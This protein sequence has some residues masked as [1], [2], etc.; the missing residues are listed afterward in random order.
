MK[1]PEIASLLVKGRDIAKDGYLSE[2]VSV[3]RGR[4]SLFDETIQVVLG[5]AVETPSRF[6]MSKL[7]V[8]FDEDLDPL[9]K[10]DLWDGKNLGQE[11]VL[12]GEKK[13]SLHSSCFFFDRYG[14]D[15]AMADDGLFQIPNLMVALNFE[16]IRTTRGWIRPWEKFD[17]TREAEDT[18][19][20]TASPIMIVRSAESV[21]MPRELGHLLPA[22]EDEGHFAAN[23]FAEFYRELSFRRLAAVLPS[24]LWNRDSKTLA[25]VRGSV[26]REGEFDP[27]ATY[28]ANVYEVIKSACRWIY[29]PSSQAEVRHGLLTSELARLW[30]QSSSWFDGLKDRLQPSLESARTAYQLHVGSL[31]AES[32]RSLAELRKALIEESARVQ[33]MTSELLTSLWRDFLIATGALV[34]HFVALAESKPENRRWV[35]SAAVIFVAISGVLTYTSQLR[36]LHVS[37]LALEAWRKRVYSFVTEADY[38]ALAAEPMGKVNRT[39]WFIA[40]PVALLYLA[41]LVLLLYFGWADI[42]T[43]FPKSTPSTTGG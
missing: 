27:S 13:T 5:S 14:L 3:L 37:K 39:Y 7:T 35:V 21:P 33:R 20:D 17:E 29:C 2:T 41:L 18:F 42:Q 8:R 40:V 19:H 16:P 10:D 24:E 26:I 30:H 23:D 25:V 34:T 22:L 4:V 12:L 36:G 28:D 6:G 1:P 38:Q 9:T 15:D 43:W 31:S 11:V 32:L